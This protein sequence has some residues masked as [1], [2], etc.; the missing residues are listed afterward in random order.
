MYQNGNK[1]TIPS[2]YFGQVSSEKS[3]KT[4]SDLMHQIQQHFIL[5]VNKIMSNTEQ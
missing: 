4:T 1:L 2:S 3:H 5:L